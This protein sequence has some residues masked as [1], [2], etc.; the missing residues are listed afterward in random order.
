MTPLAPGGQNGGAGPVA[1]TLIQQLS[2]IAPDQQLLLLTNADSDDE[3]SGLDT[4][5]VHRLCVRGPEVAAPA[6]K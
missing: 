1:T 6:W 2:Q 4:A 3:L 5:N